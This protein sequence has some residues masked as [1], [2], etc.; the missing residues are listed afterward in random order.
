MLSQRIIACLDVKDG[1]VVKGIKFR[2]HVVLGDALEFAK[3]YSDQGI[4]ELVFYDITASSESRSVDPDFVKK[5]SK[6]LNIPFCVA[7]GIRSVDHARKILNAGADKVSI[8]SPALERPELIQEIADEFGSQSL[9]VGV[10][11]KAEDS[12]DWVYMY[13]G[14][15]TKTLKSKKNTWDW[16]KEVQ[17]LGAGEI[18]LNCMNSDGTGEGFDIRQLKL[19]RE[20]LTIPLVASGGAKTSKHFKDVFTEAKVDA[21]LAAGAFH[22]NE[23]KIIDLKNDLKKQGLEIRI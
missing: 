2:E 22:R 8:N 14:D 17:D 15:E 20:I 21:A 4:D 1:Q 11:S 5:L 16:L 7:G 3:K 6:E 19:A 9:V 23:L 13:T 18:V 12:G 10:D